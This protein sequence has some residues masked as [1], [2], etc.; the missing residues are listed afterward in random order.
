MLVI[1]L[2][3]LGVLVVWGA[4]QARALAAHVRAASA[5]VQEV[6]AATGAGDLAAAAA[7]TEAAARETSAARRAADSVPFVVGSLVPGKPGEVVGAVRTTVGA[8]DQAVGEGAVP[9]LRAAS[10]ALSSGSA[11][12][13]DGSLDPAGIAVLAQDLAPAAEA[14]RSARDRAAAVDV[15]GLPPGLSGGV[16]QAQSGVDQLAGG[17]SRG[18]A[19]LAA[20]PGILGGDGPKSYLVAFQNTAELRPTG[21]II[22]TW[23]LLDVNDGRLS[24]SDAGS[25]DDLDRLTGPVRDLGPEHRALYPAEQIS[26]SQNVGLSP[27]FPYAAQLLTDLWTAQGRPA[28]DGVIAVDP[29]GLAPLLR[30]AGVVEV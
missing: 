24:L 28:P 9:A 22:G 25:N 20:L 10:E 21:G 17:L 30:G 26:Y 19:L 16:A 3:L 23:A 13:A 15:A 2:V 5:H 4:V 6:R 7:A 1:V 12:R 29:S 18:Q 8:V 27:H 14:A 11:V